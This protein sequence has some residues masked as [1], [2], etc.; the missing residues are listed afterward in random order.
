MFGFGKRNKQQAQIDQLHAELATIK[1]QTLV[2]ANSDSWNDFFGNTKTAAGVNVNPE[3]AKKL[4]AVGACLQ[5]ICN[6][7]AAMPCSTYQRDANGNREA[8]RHD[9]WWLLNESPHPVLTAH[10][11][12]QWCLE[13]MLL[14]G[15]AISR[16]VRDKLGA[17]AQIEP[18]P[19]ECVVVK[20]DGAELI[21]LINDGI[22]RKG[23]VQSEILH[24]PGFSF[25]G[26]H[27]QSAI[28]SWARNAI[29]CGLA[30]DEYSA[31]Y[32]A[33]GASP[34]VVVT[35]PQ[36]VSPTQEQQ[37]A[38]RAQFEE[39]YSGRGNRHRPALL[40]NGGNLTPVSVNPEDSQLLE[41]RRFN[42]VDVCRAFLVSPDLIGENTTSAWGTGLEQRMIAHVKHT[43][44][45]HAKK[46]EQELNRKLFPRSLRMF[47][48][49]NREGLLSGDSKAEAEY[50]ARAL[51]GPGAQGWMAIN[52][53]R[54][55]KN[56]PPDAGADSNTVTRAGASAPAS[57]TPQPEPTPTEAPAP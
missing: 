33:N 32:F 11:Y 46:I 37:N 27:G 10:T 1:N 56:L 17:V 7:V 18:I 15:D 50:F 25:N 54:R 47:V 14:R 19:R 35:Y 39:R 28:K 16:L 41:T 3:N 21:Y 24:F 2:A 31:E 51:G 5:L 30:S 44:D 4:S 8:V 29:A 40:V 20:R 49:F 53:V 36:G 43:I 52:E 34:S 45:P 26:L 38:L 57:A 22:S 48:E 13:S 6:G 55:I 42:V 12:W 9:Y 23:L